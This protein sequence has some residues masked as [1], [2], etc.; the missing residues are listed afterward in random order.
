MEENAHQQLS[1]FS[2]YAR[3]LK[4]VAEDVSSL[5]VAVLFT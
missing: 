5:G 2:S 4:Q 1:E 3:D